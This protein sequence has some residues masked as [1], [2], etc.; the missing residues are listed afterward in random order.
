MASVEAA[1]DLETGNF[2]W[3]HFGDAEVHNF[4][5]EDH[6]GVDVVDEDVG[7]VV[8]DGQ[9]EYLENRG[10]DGLSLGSVAREQLVSQLEQRNHHFVTEVV[11]GDLMVQGPATHARNR[12]Q[13]FH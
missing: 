2:E 3:E 11:Q 5:A 7:Q 1:E 4:L 12:L 9:V 6:K 8:E 13:S 10:E